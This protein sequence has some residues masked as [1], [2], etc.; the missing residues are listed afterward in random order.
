[1]WRRRASAESCG[2]ARLDLRG[3]PSESRRPWIDL[4]C[5]SRQ[6]A[7][8]DEVFS[9]EPPQSPEAKFVADAWETP[10]PHKTKSAHPW[11]TDADWTARGE[12]EAATLARD[13]GEDDSFAD[14]P[15]MVEAA[16][17]RE[18][19]RRGDI[20][21]PNAVTDRL[22]ALRVSR[23]T[24]ATPPRRRQSRGQH[25]EADVPSP[26]TKPAVTPRRRRA[27]WR[28]QHGEAD[29]ASPLTDGSPPLEPLPQRKVRPEPYY[30]QPVQ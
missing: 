12:E 29:V 25:G 27:A 20:A 8:E 14:L 4:L 3:Q 23:T 19:R 11:S 5:G 6:P 24:V 30:S 10:R 1:M 2:P 9:V 17:R 26:L 16:T 21:S 18:L 7:E 28:G 13:D 15:Q 22:S